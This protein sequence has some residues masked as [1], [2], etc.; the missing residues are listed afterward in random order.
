MTATNSARYRKQSLAKREIPGGLAYPASILP[1]VPKAKRKAEKEA[2]K[3]E[4]L[5]QNCEKRKPCQSQRFYIPYQK[6]KVGSESQRIKRNRS[7]PRDP[8]R[9]GENSLRSWLRKKINLGV[10]VGFEVFCG[11]R[12]GIEVE[13]RFQTWNR[14]LEKFSTFSSIASLGPFE[15]IYKK[16]GDEKR[17]FDTKS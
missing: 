4:K 1:P 6:R 7:E 5:M 13:K 9:D 11:F 8:S 3:R 14:S 15:S 17:Y 2:E 10:E 16:G 12:F